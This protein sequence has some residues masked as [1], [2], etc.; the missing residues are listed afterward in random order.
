MSDSAEQT[1][2]EF[3]ARL[4]RAD[5]AGLNELLDPALTVD[6]LTTGEH[7]DGAPAFVRL[8]AEYPGRWRATVLDLVADGDRAVSSTRVAAGDGSET[9]YVTSFATVRG[10]LVTRLTELWA[11]ADQPVDTRRRPV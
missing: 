9:H 8:N 10:G 6:Y 1:L 2:R 5:W 4:D 7:F 3:W 11:E